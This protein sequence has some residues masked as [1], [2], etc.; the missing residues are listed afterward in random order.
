M[1]YVNTGFL[2]QSPILNSQFSILFKIRVRHTSPS[3]PISG[4]RFPSPT[5]GTPPAGLNVTNNPPESHLN[6]IQEDFKWTS[7]GVRE[8]DGGHPAVCFPL[9]LKLNKQ[10]SPSPAIYLGQRDLRR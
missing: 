2:P 10:P 7:R 4:I 9:C 6:R 3:I 8:V 1:F 5:R